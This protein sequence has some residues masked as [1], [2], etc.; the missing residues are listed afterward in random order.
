MGID[1]AIMP[2]PMSEF[3]AWNHFQVDFHERQTLLTPV[4]DA[5]T[6]S[7]FRR[8]Y[9]GGEVSIGRFQG[10]TWWVTPENCIEGDLER[11]SGIVGV[12]VVA[13]Y[14]NAQRLTADWIRPTPAKRVIHRADISEL[15]L[16]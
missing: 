8:V 5:E 9:T 16:P 11:L 14:R 6:Q 15:P 3:R 13:A 7:F 1:G 4:P 12:D 10:H 2:C